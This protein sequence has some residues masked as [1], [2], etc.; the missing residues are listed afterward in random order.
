MSGR[1]DTRDAKLRKTVLSLLKRCQVSRAVRRL[2]SHSQD[3]PQVLVALQAKYTERSRDLPS[4]AQG[5][6]K[7]MDRM[8]GLKEDLLGLDQGVAP[9][10]G[11]LR[12][13][14]L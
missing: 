14:H 10:F 5:T 6:V 1:R 7:W 2:C 9:C 8:E 4:R 13:D 12:K 11:G 3:D